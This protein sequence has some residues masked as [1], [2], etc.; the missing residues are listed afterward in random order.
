MSAQ[1]E[2]IALV[3]CC[4]QTLKRK[5]GTTRSDPNFDNFQSVK[6]VLEDIRITSHSIPKK[7]L[8][9]LYYA[10]KP[11]TEWSFLGTNL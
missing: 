4:I 1:W 2:T 5:V 6:S 10:Y 3:E 7:L 9:E 8:F 11:N